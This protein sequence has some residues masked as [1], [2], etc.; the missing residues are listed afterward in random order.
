MRSMRPLILITNDDGVH[1]PGLHALAECV[2]DFADVLIAAPH[3]Q[4]TS[5]SRAKKRTSDSG[6]LHKVQVMLAGKMHTA[7]GIVGT[8]AIAV[9]HGVLELAPRKPDL[10]LSGINYGE[11]IGYALTTGGTIGAAMEAGAFQIPAIAVSQE[12]PISMNHTETYPKVE[13]SAAQFFAR[14]LAKQVLEQGMPADVGLFNLNI[15]TDAKPTT[16]LRWTR[17][18]RINYYQW[19]RHKCPDSSQAFELTVQKLSQDCESDSDVQAIAV[20][21]VVS[22]TPLLRNLTDLR[23]L[24]AL[25]R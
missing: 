12:T 2:C 10:C 15:P 20:D 7:Y 18:S 17:Q 23:A 1:S 16:E 9:L 25:R 3:E 8:P 19:S 14:L 13:W 6:T 4:Q 5:M 22:V 11:N 24:D 21:R